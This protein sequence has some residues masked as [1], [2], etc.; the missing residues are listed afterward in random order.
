MKYQSTRQVAMLLGLN[1]SRLAR[2][3]WDCRLTPPERGPGGVF[4][5]TFRDIQRA[6]WLLRGRD[7]DDVLGGTAAEAVRHDG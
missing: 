2:A 1:P 6:S 7:A 3:I 4:L 5:W